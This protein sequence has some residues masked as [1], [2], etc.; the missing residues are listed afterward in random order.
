MG[1]SMLAVLSIIFI[2]VMLFF[3]GASLV[4]GIPF[5][6]NDPEV[7]GPDIFQKLVPMSAHEASSMYR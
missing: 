3:S 7:S 1:V 6:W 4:K 5:N 2:F